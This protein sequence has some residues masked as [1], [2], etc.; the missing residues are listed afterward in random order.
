[1]QKL[2][3]GIIDFRQNKLPDYRR[4]FMELARGQAP[5]AL[6]IAC[7]DSR[8]VPNLFAS[9]NPGDLFVI[10]NMGNLVPPCICGIE[11]EQSV[12]AAIEFC[13]QTLAVKDIIV[14]GHSDCGAI[15]ALVSDPKG[16]HPSLND[17]LKHA[18]SALEVYEKHQDW[19]SELPAQFLN[20]VSQLNVLQQMDHLKTHLPVQEGLAAGT[21]RLHGWWFDIGS[22]DVSAYNAELKKF[23]LIDESWAARML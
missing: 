6:L 19:L 13:L 21:L 4:K 9:T 14:C 15:R 18:E 11:K 5:D 16:R 1:M 23:E 20:Q 12:A 22:A 8:V 10:R 7:S 3:K 17:W 2:I